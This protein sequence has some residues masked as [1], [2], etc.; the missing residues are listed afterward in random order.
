MKTSTKQVLTLMKVLSWVAFIGF[1]I[2]T[3]SLLVSFAVSQWVNPVAAR[4]LY[5]G[6]DLSA[7]RAMSEV[8][9]IA[10]VATVVLLT[11]LQA[12]MLYQVIN[13]FL[14]VDLDHPFG[15]PLARLVARI[16]YVA[17]AIGVLSLL[18]TRYNESLVQ[19]GIPSPGLDAFI[20]SGG[21]FLVFGGILFVITLVI[22]RGMEI[23]MEND[24]TV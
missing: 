8:Q 13:V 24:L 3:G 4:D 12:W 21:V 20:G 9:Y 22:R 11:A 5:L 7:L 14:K 15:E 10:M 17:M 23:Q 19:K 2:K 16:S 18:A 6:L 1:C